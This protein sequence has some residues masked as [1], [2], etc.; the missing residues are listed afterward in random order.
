M[1]GYDDNW[2]DA[3]QNNTAIYTDLPGGEYRFKVRAASFDKQWSKEASLKVYMQ[4]PW[5][6]QLWFWLLCAVVF[7]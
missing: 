4:T 1:E 2:I 7:Y 3:G 5:Y 6:L